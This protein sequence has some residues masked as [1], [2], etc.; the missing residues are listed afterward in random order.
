MTEIMFTCSDVTEEAGEGDPCHEWDWNRGL[1]LFSARSLAMAS[2]TVLFEITINFNI[3]PD[4]STTFTLIIKIHHSSFTARGR[5]SQQPQS[6][7][8]RIHLS[9]PFTVLSPSRGQF[10]RRE[11]YVFLTCHNSAAT[12]LKTN[13]HKA[14]PFSAFANHCYE[15]HKRDVKNS[16]VSKVR[17]QIRPQKLIIWNIPTPEKRKKSIGKT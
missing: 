15:L 4:F 3:T 12:V 9:I 14:Q 10:A 11:S 7:A 6:W 16:D 17:E 13:L 8:Y 2:S 1:L 5:H